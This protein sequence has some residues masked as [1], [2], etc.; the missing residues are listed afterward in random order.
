MILNK[1]AVVASSILV[2]REK[3]QYYRCFTTLN[4]AT[5]LVGSVTSNRNMSQQSVKEKFRLP[6]RLEG[7]KK[8]MWTEYIE[9]AIK[10]KP[11]D[12]GQGF[13]DYPVPSY[14]TDAYTNAAKNDHLLHQYTRGFGHLRLV[15]AISKLYSNLVNR[16]IDFRNEVLISSGAYQAI[17]TVIHGHVDVGDEVIIVEPFFDCYEP[18]VKM[19]GGIPRFIALKPTTSSVTSTADWVLDIDELENIFS[20]K[21][22]MFI[23]NNPNNPLGKVFTVNELKKIAELCIKYNVLCL[24]DEVYEWITYDGNEMIRMCTL[25]GMWERTITVGSAGKTFSTTGWKIGWS[26]GPAN[27]MTNMQMVHQNS[28]YTC[29]TPIQEAL[30]I[31]FETELLR[32]STNECYFNALPQELQKKRDFTAAFLRDIGMNVIT[33]QGGYFLMADWSSLA[34]KTDLTTE[35]D[36]RRDYRFTKWMIKNIGIQGI[37]PS[38]FY[39]DVHKHLGENYVRYCFFKNDDYLQKCA[40]LLKKWKHNF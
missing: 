26:F 24:A 28:V 38:A 20:S 39:A 3:S 37:P 19:A 10:H 4:R 21:T 14:I 25:D 35:S 1:S 22:K 17:Y 11:L 2:L 23:L 7:S 12:L 6:S 27:L 16:P 33:P 29:S 34:D 18:M 15:Q 31:A 32:L 13:C 36:T 40:D 30:A 5:F 8:S 9:L